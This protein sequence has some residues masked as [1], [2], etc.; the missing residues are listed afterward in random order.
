[1]PFKFRVGP[2]VLGAMMLL[3]AAGATAQINWSSEVPVNSDAATDSTDQFDFPGDMATDGDGVWIAVYEQRDIGENPT[4]TRIHFARSTD[5]GRTWSATQAIRDD[6]TEFGTAPRIATDGKGLWIAVWSTAANV[7]DAGDDLDIVAAISGNNGA[8][9]GGPV[10]VNSDANEDDFRDVEP[11]IAAGAN[12]TWLVAWNRAGA[13]FDED[14]A[15][16][17]AESENTSSWTMQAQLDRFDERVP[18]LATSGG[19]VWVVVSVSTRSSFGENDVC[20][21]RSADDGMTWTTLARLND[22]STQT[23]ERHSSPDVEIDNEGVAVTVWLMSKTVNGNAYDEPHYKVSE[24]TGITWGPQ[25]NFAPFMEPFFSG[26][27]SPSIVTDGDDNW[28]AS[29]NSTRTYGLDAGGDRDVWYSVT[30]DDGT[31]WTAPNFV[32]TD[33]LLGGTIAEVDPQITTDGKGAYVA[34]YS[35]LKSAFGNPGNSV[36]WDVFAQTGFFGGFLQGKITR[37]GTGTPIGSAAVRVT[38]PNGFDRVAVTDR[39]GDYALDNVPEGDYTLDV[40]ATKIDGPN[41]FAKG[42]DSVT[43]VRGAVIKA[44]FALEPEAVEDGVVGTVFGQVTPGSSENR[45]PL[46]G[47]RIV[48]LAEEDKG[49]EDDTVTFSTGDGSYAISGLESLKGV[50][51]VVR[52]NFNAAGYVPD[53]RLPEIPPGAAAESN[54]TLEQK[55]IGFA[56]TLTGVVVDD[57]TSAP[58]T[59]A[60]VELDGPVRVSRTTEPGDDG[61]YLFDAIPSSTYIVRTSATG[62]V[63]DISDVSVPGDVVT[64]FNV[65][66][67]P[68]DSVITIVG[69]VNGD[70][71]VNAIDVQLAINAVLGFALGGLDADVNKDNQLNALDVQLVINGALGLSGK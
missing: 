27:A 33:A 37:A 15:I 30:S 49:D 47:V 7:N 34:T 41:D 11:D 46:V 20:W 69:D 28:I 6:G 35:T 23:G 19:G 10:F 13:D 12:E 38:G 21:S 54:P 14:I 5:N 66:L 60:R 29:W 44:D 43:V 70:D 64:A 31:T 8:T 62:Y 71:V 18:R 65:A 48:A 45:V 36:D 42:S 4:V 67:I 56:S 3:M 50:N 26:G 1:M 25:R 22:D 2:I 53:D 39:R 40:F 55:A 51:N 16:A 9:W 52:L 24:D 63:T 17:R 68:E 58:I 61:A 57:E 59:G 32:N